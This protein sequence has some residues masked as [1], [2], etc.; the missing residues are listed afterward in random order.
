LAWFAGHDAADFHVNGLRDSSG[1]NALLAAI[2]LCDT[3]SLYGAGLLS[4]GGAAADKV[5]V[6]FFD[7]AVGACLD[8]GNATLRGEAD[9]RRFSRATWLKDRLRTEMLLHVLHAM[10]IIRW[11][12]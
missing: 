7:D 11:V 8:E 4:V 12:Q 3:V 6:H 5:Y 1:G 2:S 9:T 10:G